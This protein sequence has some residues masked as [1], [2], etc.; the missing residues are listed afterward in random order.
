MTCPHCASIATTDRPD[1]TELGYRRFCCHDCKRGFNERTGTLFNRLQYPTDVVSLV[2]LWRFRYKFGVSADR[3]H[4]FERFIVQ[5]FIAF[6][7]TRRV[8]SPHPSVTAGGDHM[9]RHLPRFLVTL[10]LGFLVAALGAAAQPTG[11]TARV[12]Y[13]DLRE[14]S[15]DNTP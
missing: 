7:R 2:V 3:V 5:N 12:G 4:G 6:L 13:L 15:C 9:R 11:K 10:T 14:G 1:R 8:E